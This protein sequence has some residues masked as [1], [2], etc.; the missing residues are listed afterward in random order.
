MA[1]AL[2]LVTKSTDSEGGKTLKD[3]LHACVIN[4]DDGNTQAQV[5]AQAESQ[6]RA[7]G[8]AVLDGYFD[9]AVEISDLASGPLQ[10][11]GDA[12]MFHDQFTTK[13]EG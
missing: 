6:A 11:D 4:S 2:W 1:E 8:F 9:T 10:D 12:Y 5:I 13:V 3:K 7:G